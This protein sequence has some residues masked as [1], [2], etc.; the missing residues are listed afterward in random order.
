[1]IQATLFARDWRR[2]PHRAATDFQE[3]LRLHN[4]GDS[5]GIAPEEFSLQDLAA[6]FVMEDDRPLGLAGVKRVFDPKGQTIQL[7]EATSAVDSTTFANIT[8]QLLVSKVLQ[9]YQAEDFV[10]SKLVE[11]IPTKLDGEKLPGITKISDPGQDELVVREGQEYPRFGFGEE[12]VET[13]STTKRGLIIPVTKE[14]IFF[15]RTNL[16][17]SRAQEVGEVLGLNKEKRLVD[18]VI[19]GTK[20]YS[21]NGTTYYTYYST[22][23]TGA[24][25]INHLS[26]NQLVDWTDIDNAEN[27]FAEMTDPNT[28]EPIVMGA[29][30]DLLVCPQ[31]RFSANRLLNANETRS[32][33]SN[34]V[35]GGNPLAGMGIRLYS[36]RLLYTRLIATDTYGHSVS[37]ANAKGYWWYGDLKKAFAYMENWPLTVT[38]SAQNNP[39]EFSQ[40]IVAEFK[41]SERGAAAVKDPRF[42]TRN[43]ADATSSSSG[44]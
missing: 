5:G 36:S 16:V 17:L 30:R 7:T 8:G 13:P 4:V 10:L 14:A 41:A 25:Y 44:S 1:M 43:R 35:V 24:P 12:Y 37:A 15:D 18:L 3:C 39:S 6:E 40:D 19:G 32:G 38:R 21:R 28:S 9:A 22:N 31:L 33:S 2:D 34:I 26:G 27:L 42:I 11:T 23:D 20:V 29:G